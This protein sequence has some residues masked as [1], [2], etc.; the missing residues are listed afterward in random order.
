MRKGEIS[1]LTLPPQMWRGYELLYPN[2]PVD[3]TLQFEVE[4]IS[5]L[6][7]VDVCNDGGLLKKILVKSVILERPQKKDQVTGDQ[8]QVSWYNLITGV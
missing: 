6:K 1:I 5:W 4:L 7:V 3:A 8:L 2:I